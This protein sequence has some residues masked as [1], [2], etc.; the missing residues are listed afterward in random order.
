MIFGDCPCPRFGCRSFLRGSS[1]LCRARFRGGE[2]V[3]VARDER[4]YGTNACAAYHPQGWVRG[5]LA[6]G[7]DVLDYW[8]GDGSFKQ[9]AFLLRK[10]DP[11]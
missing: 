1:L 9:D 6:A 11:V 8:P 4:D 10:P 2:L 3:V 7:L 5:T